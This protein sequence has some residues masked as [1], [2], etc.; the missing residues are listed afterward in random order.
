MTMMAIRKAKNAYFCVPIPY[1]HDR[2]ASIGCNGI[3]RS[4]IAV[5]LAWL[6]NG[7]TEEEEEGTNDQMLSFA[8]IVSFHQ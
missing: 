5:S 8:L 2:L 4:V 1:S 7:G 6:F 3:E